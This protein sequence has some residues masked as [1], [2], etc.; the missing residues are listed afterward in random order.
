LALATIRT[1]KLRL[2]SQ[3]EIEVTV[4]YE[5]R[6]APAKISRLPFFEPPHKKAVNG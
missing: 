1:D 4:E 2:G 5:R 3:I 6:L